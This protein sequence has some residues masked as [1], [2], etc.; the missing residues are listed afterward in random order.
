MLGQLPAGASQDP[1]FDDQWALDRIN[2]EQA[3]ASSTG[4]GVRIGIVDTGI[5]LAHED[6]AN[7]VV[8]HA[9]CVG[10][11]GDAAKCGGSGQDDQGHG[12]HV[13]GIAAATKDNHKGIAGVAPDA[14]LVVAKVLDAQGRGSTTDVLAGIKWA[15]DNGAQVV[16]L[17]LGDPTSILTGLVGSPHALAE[18]LQYAWAHGAIPV[19]AAGNSNTLG[20]GLEGASNN[21][22][23][24]VVVSASGPDNRPAKYSTPTGEARFAILAPGGAG[25]GEPTGDVYSTMWD[26]EKP[27]SYA[28]LAGTSMAAPHVSGALALLL[29]EGLNPVDAVK[30]MMASADETVSCGSGSPTCA[31]LLDVGAAVAAPQR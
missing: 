7:Q 17:S 1:S 22:V 27:N 18:G 20:L 4:E 28:A 24:A 6:L 16:N 3:W 14:D 11:E 13:A 23:N 9:S 21:G 19:V 30:T 26:P 5:D 2:A 15:V 31:G 10:A 8:A 12:T 29:A 25:T